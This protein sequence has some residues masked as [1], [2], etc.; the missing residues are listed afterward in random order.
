M[1]NTF[2]GLEIG[3]RALN[4]FRQAIET[5]GHNISNA[6]IE[7][8]SR[9]RV[10][11]SPTD[12]YTVPGINSPAGAGQIGTGVGI[13]AIIRIR[14]AFLDEQ[15][16]QEST[17]EGYWE[18]VST[19]LE[20]V[21]MFLGEP[22]ENAI[23][24][25]LSK[26]NQALNELQKNP[27][28]SATRESFLRELD[29]FCTT[30]NHIYENL[31]EYRSS[32]D[33]EVQLKV[34][35]ANSLLD[36]IAALNGQIKT[37]KAL[38]GE[39]NDLMDQRDNLIDQLSKL[40]DVKVSQA[41][42]LGSISVSLAGRI[43]VQDDLARHL[44]LVPQDG[45]N[46]FYDV[47]IED[48]EFA[49]SNNP[50]T[51]TAAIS[52]EATEGVHSVEISRLANE[53]H[54]AI[55]D[56]TGISGFASKDESLGI[57]GGFS[58]QVGTNGYSPSSSSL[59][60]G[61][62]LTSPSTGDL[63]HYTFRAAAGGKEQVI[64]ADWDTTSGSWIINGSFD[65][66]NQLETTDLANFINDPSN[67]VPL[68]AS[69][70][71]SG[72]KI[73]FKGQEGHLVSLTDIEGNLVS[74]MGIKKDFP[75][76]QISITE[77]D[78]LQ[79]IVNKINSAYSINSQPSSPEEWLHASIE[80]AVNGTFYIKLE[81]NV[82]GEN[83]RINIAPSEGRSLF[84]AQKLGLVDSDGK[85]NIIQ[86]SEDALFKVDSQN[87]L[88]ATNVFTKARPITSYNA[89][90]AD[91]LE[92]V[93]PGV[94]FHLH[95]VGRTD[96]RI[97]RHVNGGYIAGLIM[98]RDELVRE[99]M[100]FL[101]DFAKT[102]SDQMNAIH[103]SGH[104]ISS[105]ADLTGTPLLSPIDREKEAASALS[106][107]P[108][109]WERTYLLATASDDGTGH[110]TGSGDATKALELI[111]L[112]S[113]R[114]FNEDSATAEDYYQSFIASVGSQSRQAA[115]MEENQS[116]LTEQI[117]NQKQ[118]IMGVNI[119]EEMI[120]IITYQHSYQ[121]ISRYITVLDE[122]LDKVINGMGIAGR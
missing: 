23:S 63:T 76:V 55:G 16:R 101:N 42:S 103:Y 17:K 51:A 37:I 79:T 46:G 35:E 47:Q 43:L 57:E 15:F 68:Y 14:D 108:T 40:V 27:D 61:V 120:N 20:Y 111:Q 36:R 109:L 99:A 2:S 44:V 11:A 28:S 62:I 54:W 65:A 49:T 78:S 86:H 41:D 32:L 74:L 91:T 110:T 95:G 116:V 7:G 115:V 12:P 77:E 30:V 72:E 59:A 64:T 90:K 50:Q 113:K 45:N 22:S 6:D 66:G 82:I 19:S 88:S 122:L 92:E 81:S 5:S 39:P 73:T 97:E 8:Y 67:G 112:F 85:T 18:A 29:N 3:R 105:G 26:L 89:F 107:N 31:D 69:V 58:I 33:Q 75:T 114:V 121:A 52:P 104:G 24:G 80:Q 87:Y 60:G 96:I 53:K 25:S 93:I 98:S 38:G 106:V 1:S 10:E 34:D 71:P 70:D 100:N 118:S 83:Y 119:D 13:D 9:Q 21:E 94:E 4:Y 56:S 48:N 84:A 102:L 117:S